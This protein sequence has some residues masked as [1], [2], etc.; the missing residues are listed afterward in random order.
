MFN[1]V[2]W[3]IAIAV[4]FGAGYIM[5][6][7]HK[8]HREDEEE[9]A[10]PTVYVIERKLYW[11]E[12]INIAYN[13]IQEI[14]DENKDKF[15]CL[16]LEHEEKPYHSNRFYCRYRSIGNKYIIKMTLGEDDMPFFMIE[17]NAAA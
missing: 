12:N 6:A 5:G 7:M 16:K 17:S 15:E 13:K 4:A 11:L 3:L 2:F 9:L 14:F 1:E 8:K 10:D